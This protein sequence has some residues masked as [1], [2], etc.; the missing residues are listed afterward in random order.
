MVG[1]DVPTVVGLRIIPPARLRSVPG[2]ASD[3]GDGLQRVT[4]AQT[5]VAA[6][7]PASGLNRSGTRA[8][9]TTLE[10]GSQWISWSS[11]SMW[12]L[13]VWRMGVLDTPPMKK[14]SSIRTFQAWRVRM[15]RS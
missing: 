4:V 5:F 13:K 11:K 9:G 2:W 10:A 15:T 12:G 6:T 3:E 7:W 8:V 1:R 14:A